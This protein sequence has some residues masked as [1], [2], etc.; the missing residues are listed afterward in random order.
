[1]LLETQNLST[2]L[3]LRITTQGFIFV[4]ILDVFVINLHNLIQISYHRLLNWRIHS[5]PSSIKKH[6]VYLQSFIRNESA[7]NRVKEET[8]ERVNLVS[9]LAIVFA[10]NWFHSSLQVIF[11]NKHITHCV[12]C[13][14]IKIDYSHITWY[15]DS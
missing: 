15:V 8:E 13:L 6:C 12:I 1:M 9:V 10:Q 2:C 3:E 7:R 4:Q 11:I 14:L 5:H